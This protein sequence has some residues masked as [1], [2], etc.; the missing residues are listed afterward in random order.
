MAVS[1]ADKTGG[2]R[3]INTGKHVYSAW[4]PV[5]ERKGAYIE[6]MNPYFNPKNADLNMDVTKDSCPKTLDILSRT[7]YVFINPDWTDAE[8]AERIAVTRNAAS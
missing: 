5:L 1:F 7:V 2:T 3:P 8:I 6:G 4:T